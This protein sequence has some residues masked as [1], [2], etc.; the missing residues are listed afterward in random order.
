ME[1]KVLK[2]AVIVFPVRGDE[3][4]LAMKTQKIGA[5]CWNGFG[6]G[7]EPDETPLEAARRELWEESGLE[8]FLDHLE[9]IAMVDFHNQKSDGSVFTCRCHVFLAHLWRGRTK[10]TPEMTKPTWFRRDALPF[11]EMMPADRDWLPRALSEK[12]IVAEA[13]YAPFQKSLHKPTLV[14]EVSEFD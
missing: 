14:R 11:D 8:A 12:K 6:G 7:I 10:E 4:L 1:E 2:N 13:W 3:I 9:K 5:G